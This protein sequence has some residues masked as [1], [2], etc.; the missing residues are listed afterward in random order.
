MN[1]A[2]NNY[3]NLKK[4]FIYESHN[5]YKKYNITQIK[6]EIKEVYKKNVRSVVF[7]FKNI[8]ILEKF[9][10]LL[11]NSILI[12]IYKND[13]IRM[14]EK[15]CP[16]I[17]L[18]SSDSMEQ[19]IWKIS[20]SSTNELTISLSENEYI[21]CLY[22]QI[23]DDHSFNPLFFIML[24]EEITE[25]S[26]MLYLKD[27]VNPTSNYYLLLYSDLKLEK[28]DIE[29]TIDGYFIY[30]GYG[31]I[32]IQIPIL[33]HIIKQA[34]HKKQ[35]IKLLTDTEK[36]FK[37]LHYFLPEADVLLIQC[38]LFSRFIDKSFIF[39]DFYKYKVLSITAVDNV[40]ILDH[41]LLINSFFE[42]ICTKFYDNKKWWTASEVLSSY[43]K[44]FMKYK[45]NV[46]K[47]QDNKTFKFWVCVQRNS[48][49]KVNN[50]K[51][52]HLPWSFM[53]NVISICHQNN[54]GVINIDPDE[55]N[56]DKYDYNY[57]ALGLIKIFNVLCSVDAFLG[58]DSCFGHACALLNIPSVSCIS[59]TFII[60]QLLGPSFRPI[61]NNYSFIPTNPEKP[62][63][64][65]NR[66]CNILQ[67]ILKGKLVLSNEFIPTKEIKEFHE[68]EF[69]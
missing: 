21:F 12:K 22:T 46:K 26:N 31:D 29:N 23:L 61:S 58:I 42:L 56:G 51:V 69:I 3:D 49:T 9:P 54:I 10:F 7:S 5:I 57:G 39:K 62:S 14:I 67:N 16:I 27:V 30:E 53:E 2:Q 13:T 50:F 19:I 28:E 38:I 20:N 17:P 43:K 68:Y 52:K 65:A 48:G 1:E 47:F 18:D 32:L 59:S 55:E 36:K 24:L 60:F 40:K 25:F 35:K 64:D 41:N 37:M 4:K 15:A 11:L 33:Y 44:Y 34:Q 66:V 45:K 6:N 8:S 63:F